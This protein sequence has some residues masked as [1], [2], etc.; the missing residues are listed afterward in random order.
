[1]QTK[2]NSLKQSA[3][4]RCNSRTRSAAVD[5]RPPVE[6]PDGAEEL[7]QIRVHTLDL[8]ARCAKLSRQI[9]SAFGGQAFLPDLGPLDPANQRRFWACFHEHRKVT[10]LL[11]QAFELW[12]AS[13]GWKKEPS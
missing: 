6:P 10:K 9:D 8:L 4:N 5:E 11:I 2:R 1:M 3:G 12:R 13:F 7:T